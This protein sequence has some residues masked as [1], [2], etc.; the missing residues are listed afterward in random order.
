MMNPAQL[1]FAALLL[2]LIPLGAACSRTEG[3]VEVADVTK[4]ETM[5]LRKHPEQGAIHGIT[6]AAAGSIRGEA[7]LQLILNGSVYQKEAIS[8]PVRI[9]FQGDWYA[10]EA[11]L[12]YVPRQVS[13]GSLLID[14]AF[15]D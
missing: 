10:D 15:H 1:R 13:G 3:Q 8:G 5:V 6:L 14:Y 12:R 9:A 7:E 4:A 11:E 2:C